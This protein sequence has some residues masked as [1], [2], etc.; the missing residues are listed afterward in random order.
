MPDFV[1]CCNEP[2]RVTWL[3]LMA[4]IKRK[5]KPKSGRNITVTTKLE[6]TEQIARLMTIKPGWDKSHGLQ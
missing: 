2:S 5:L 4:K 6:S 1:Q 3:K